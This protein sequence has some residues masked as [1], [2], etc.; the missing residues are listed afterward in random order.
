MARQLRI[1]FPGALYHVMARGNERRI[2]FVDDDD[3][4][5]FLEE[6]WKVCQHRNWLVWAYCLLA[7]HYHLLIETLTPTLSVGMRDLN[8]TH[9]QEF[10]RRHDRVG[11]LFQGRYVAKL[12]DA[13]TYLLEVWRYVVLNPVRAELCSSPSEWRWSSYPDF[14]GLRSGASD[15][16]I[17]DAVL[18]LFGGDRVRAE[19]FVEAG[20][21]APPPAGHRDNPLIIGDDAFLQRVM[22]HSPAEK[23]PEVPEPE[24]VPEA[25]PDVPAERPARNEAIRR[26]FATGAFSQAAVARHFGV[27]YSTVSRVLARGPRGRGRRGTA[28]QDVTPAPASRNGYLQVPMRQFKM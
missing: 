15:R 25:L 12:V 23:S 6:L 11:H 2:I 13:R 8:G 3:R 28:I 7:N 4:R 24:R 26:A 16:L 17:V 20:L 5:L 27:H 21:K 22:A 19:R 10:N 14:A 1:E 18:D 9:A